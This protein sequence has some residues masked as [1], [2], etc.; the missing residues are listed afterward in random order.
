MI[1]VFDKVCKIPVSKVSPKGK[2]LMGLF[3]GIPI[4][5][6]RSYLRFNKSN[7][8]KLSKEYFQKRINEDDSIHNDAPDGNNFRVSG[9]VSYPS[10][11]NQ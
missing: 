9:R 3:G 7:R 6:N 11:P 2:E 10:E 8:E 1:F 5:D 4:E